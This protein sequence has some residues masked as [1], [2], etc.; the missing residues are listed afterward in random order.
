MTLDENIIG[1]F[2]HDFM[3]YHHIGIDTLVPSICGFLMILIKQ[4]EFIDC[5][6]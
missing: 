2:L 6:I 4:F 1:S 3:E 5:D